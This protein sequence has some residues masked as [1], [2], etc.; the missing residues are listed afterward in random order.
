MIKSELIKARCTSTEK[1]YLIEYMH[2]NSYRTLSETIR[3]IINDSM[4][5]KSILSARG[6][7]NAE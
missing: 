6:A 1:Q 5:N 7:K 3:A 4:L 2:S